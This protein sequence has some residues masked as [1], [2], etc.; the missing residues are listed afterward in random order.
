[1][2]YLTPDDLSPATVAQKLD[3]LRRRGRAK[4]A[5]MGRH[6]ELLTAMHR[7]ALVDWG[8]WTI[9]ELVDTSS[10]TSP[11]RRWWPW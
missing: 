1:M 7:Q 10:T 8:C 11:R 9:W 5:G 6:G 3:A 4:W 2:A